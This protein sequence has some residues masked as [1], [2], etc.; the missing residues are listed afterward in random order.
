[1][2]EREHLDL[3]WE[4][5]EY[6][7]PLWFKQPTLTPKNYILESKLYGQQILVHLQLSGLMHPNLLPLFNS[8]LRIPP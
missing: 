7:E 1:M 4:H 3:Y 2:R 6:K 5:P 8:P